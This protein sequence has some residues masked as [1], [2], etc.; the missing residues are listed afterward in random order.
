MPSFRSRPSR[1][2][3]IFTILVGIGMLVFALS[4]VGES[5]SGRGPGG[6]FF[7]LW[8]LVLLGIIGYHFYN[9]ATGKGYTESIDFDDSTPFHDLDADSSEPV[10]ARLRE[11]DS[12]KEEG[13]ISDEE[14]EKER[15]RILA[16]I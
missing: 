6:A 12:L 7:A 11:L 10:A 16:S 14:Y 15:Q 13:L 3:S 8:V 4:M 9:A 1:G 5:G 2:M